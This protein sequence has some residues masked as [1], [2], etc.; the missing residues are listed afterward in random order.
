MRYGQCCWSTDTFELVIKG[1]NIPLSST[2]C[3]LLDPVPADCD[4]FRDVGRAPGGGADGEAM[5]PESRLTALKSCN[6]I[7]ADVVAMSKATCL[8]V[9]TLKICVF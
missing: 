7:V 8:S 9:L 4:L 3:L 2:Q 1:E 6:R 5:S